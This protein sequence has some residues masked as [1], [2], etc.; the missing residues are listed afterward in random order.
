MVVGKRRAPQPCRAGPNG[1]E[2]GEAHR[3]RAPGL[4]GPHRAQPRAPAGW[5]RPAGEGT[6]P[7]PNGRAPPGFVR[8]PPS[9]PAPRRPPKMA[10][11]QEMAP[12][13]ALAPQEGRP[14]TEG[15]FPSTAPRN[16][17]WS[18]TAHPTSK[19]TR[20]KGSPSTAMSK[21]TVGLTMTAAS[22]DKG[23]RRLQSGTSLAS[24][25]FIPGPAPPTAGSRAWTLINHNCFPD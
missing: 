20:P 15:A 18:A 9:L 13:P 19:E 4:V 25:S 1:S 14:A 22:D 11:R 6:G 12:P 10:P 17:P 5:R 24:A 16:P 23:Q 21:N 2:K 8:R 3:A 7:L